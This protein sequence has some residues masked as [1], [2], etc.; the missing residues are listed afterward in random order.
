MKFF[1]LDLLT[2]LIS[3]FIFNSCKNQDTIGL[4]PNIPADSLGGLLDTATI[5]TNTVPDD[6]VITS[7]ITKAPMGYFADPVFGATQSD[8]ITDL[9]LPGSAAY[10]IPTGTINIDSAVL[11]LKYANGFYGDSIASKYKVNV[12]QLG[13]RIYS[14]TTY[15]NNKTWLYNNQTVI[16]TQSFYSRTH[17]SLKV[18]TIVSA[19]PDTLIKVP[20]QLRIPMDTNF[21]RQILFAPGAPVTTNLLFQNAVKGLYITIDRTHSTGPGG[22]FMIAA[23]GDS[24]IAVYIRAKNGSTIDTSVVYMNMAQHASYINHIYSAQVN[25]AITYGTADSLV[26]IQGLA[27]LRAKIR[28]PFIKSLFSHVKG[29]NSNV[30]INRAEV[31]VTIAPG[32]DIPSYLVPQPKLTLYRLDLAHQRVSVEDANTTDPRA[33]SEAVFGGNF[34]PATNQYHFLVTSYMQDLILNRTIDYGTFIAPI[35][36]TNTTSVDI[37]ATPETAGRTLAIGNSKTSPYRIKLNVIY[38]RISK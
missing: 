23:P 29:G 12:Y 17:D 11:I 8:L 37:A 16:G 25:H 32:S 3:L 18:T 20:P 9:Q 31:V 5:W 38:T 7:G 14:G 6:T 4:G 34:N 26:Y 35:D 19:G 22:T 1:R 15:Y 30:I 2:L 36:N 33:Y 21:V 27:G 10:T 28:F 13:E 24:S